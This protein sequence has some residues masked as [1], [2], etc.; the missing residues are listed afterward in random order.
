MDD[1]LQFSRLDF[2]KLSN[3]E[4]IRGLM[5]AGYAYAQRTDAA[6]GFEPTLGPQRKWLI[7]RVVEFPV[8]QLSRA[9]SLS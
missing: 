3:Y 6:G 4:G 8:R 5:S 2:I 7:T 9:L 1:Q